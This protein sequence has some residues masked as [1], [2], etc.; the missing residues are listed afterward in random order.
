MWFRN[1]IKFMKRNGRLVSGVVL[2]TRYGLGDM[3]CQYFEINA[4]MGQE[5]ELEA[6]ALLE[7]SLRAAAVLPLTLGDKVITDDTAASDDTDEAAH[8]EQGT[9]TEA[10][11]S[12]VSDTSRFISPSEFFEHWSPKRTLSF[13]CFGAVYFGF[14]GLCMLLW[15]HHAVWHDLTIAMVTSHFRQVP[16]TTCTRVCSHDCL[17]SV[18]LHGE[19]PFLRLRVKLIVPVR[20]T[21][22]DLRGHLPL[23]CSTQVSI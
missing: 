10:T 15:L 6:S 20:P 12:D 2:A 1:A 21:L 18:L 14:P 9:N 8:S 17:V 16:G 23:L 13:V 5:K 3:T 7:A 22:Q 19:I 4:L 11:E